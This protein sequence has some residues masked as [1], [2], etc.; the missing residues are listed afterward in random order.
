MAI[1]ETHRKIELQSHLDLMHLRNAALHS[2]R[3][4]VDLHFP[5]SAAPLHG[6]D[7]MRRR[8][9]E[10]VHSY[11]D[12]MFR[13]AASS[14]SAN[15]NDVDWE[16]VLVGGAD[17]EGREEEFEAYDTRLA[18]RIQELS[19]TVEGLNLSLAN[20]RRTAPRQ[21]AEAQR[22]ALMAE[23]EAHDG[24]FEQERDAVVEKAAEE[25]RLFL[26]KLDRWDDMEKSWMDST[27]GLERL[28]GM[29][30]RREPGW[31]GRGRWWLMLRGLITVF[32]LVVVV[33][34]YAGSSRFW[35]SQTSGA[36]LQRYPGLSLSS[37]LASQE[38]FTTCSALPSK[39]LWGHGFV[40]ALYAA[41]P[42][43]PIHSS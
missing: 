21:A 34:E 10:L 27:E 42:A 32:L 29:S 33:V 17:G 22:K 36:P 31:N 25:G 9:E 20:L 40:L 6:D 28:R 38:V 8:V 1:Y 30:R 3:K 24:Q 14:V 18:A 43:A 13:S 37:V 39:V 19:S 41:A 16:K 26:G 15:G 5:P 23:I 2:A 4:S 35:G 11:I 12:R 7:A